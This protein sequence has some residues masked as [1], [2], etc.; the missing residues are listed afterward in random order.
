VVLARA[1]AHGL[2]V[3]T[4][5]IEDV[6]AVVVGNGHADVIEHHPL[7]LPR[8]L[9]S[10]SHERVRRNQWRVKAGMISVENRRTLCLV[11]SP[12]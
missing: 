7:T 1:V 8:S 10:A 6:A 9:P 11:D 4:I 3:V 2:D 12:P 5:G